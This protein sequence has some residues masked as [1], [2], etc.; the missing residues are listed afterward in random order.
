MLVR[1]TGGLLLA[2]LA[3]VARPVAAGQ[4]RVIGD[5]VALLIACPLLDTLGTY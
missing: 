3:I 1:L 4:T 5:V 2:I